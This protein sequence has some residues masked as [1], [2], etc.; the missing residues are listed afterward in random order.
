[1]MEAVVG[2]MKT[3]GAALKVPAAVD[4]RAQECL[5][6]TVTLKALAKEAWPTTTNNSARCSSVPEAAPESATA[7]QWL[8]ARVEESR[9]Y[10]H[11]E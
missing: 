10:F 3:L 7:A 9:F 5:G 1:M 8:G 4:M 6:T 11:P 2:A